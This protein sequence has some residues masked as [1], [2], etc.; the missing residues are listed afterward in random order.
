MGVLSTIGDKKYLYGFAAFMVSLLL[1]AVFGE[2][3]LVDAYK[4]RQERDGI[5]AHN[6][7]LG[8]ENQRLAEEIDLLKSDKRY[9]ARVARGELGMIG[10]RE[11]IYIF[12]D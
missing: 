3:G 5:L 11:L 2:K 4:L 7:E 9:I 12:E 8:E 10:E 6:A 1:L